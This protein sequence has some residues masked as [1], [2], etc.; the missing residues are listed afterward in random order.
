MRVGAGTLLEGLGEWDEVMDVV[1]TKYINRRLFEGFTD[2]SEIL[3]FQAEFEI[4]LDSTC[5]RPK[6][7]CVRRQRRKS[8]RQWRRARRSPNQVKAGHPPL[9]AFLT[10]ISRQSS[11]AKD[12][13]KPEGIQSSNFQSAY[14]MGLFPMLREMK[15]ENTVSKEG[16]AVTGI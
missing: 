10:L 15:V 2:C 16:P 14:Y 8:R 6:A 4:Q 5:R 7:R 13:T 3:S 1:F 11:P 12:R 9:T